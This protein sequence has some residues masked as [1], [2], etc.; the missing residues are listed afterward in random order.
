MGQVSHFEKPATQP[1]TSYQMIS[2]HVRSYQ[3]LSIRPS[4]SACHFLYFF[5]KPLAD[6]WP[7]L[8][9][10]QIRLLAEAVAGSVLMGEIDLDPSALQLEETWFEAWLIL[11]GRMAMSQIGPNW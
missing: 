1:A 5:L 11:T 9:H 2:D 6:A 7:E 8:R 4:L 3:M 10:G